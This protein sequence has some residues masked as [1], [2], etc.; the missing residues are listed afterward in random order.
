MAKNEEPESLMKDIAMRK[1][2]KQALVV[3]LEERVSQVIQA[4]LMLDMHF[5]EKSGPMQCLL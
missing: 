1:N 3:T 5:D 4:I 2:M